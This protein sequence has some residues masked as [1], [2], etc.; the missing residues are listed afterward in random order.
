MRTG[1]LLAAGGR[2]LVAGATA[3]ACWWLVE[4]AVNWTVGGFVPPALL[5]RIAALDLALGA[6]FGLAVGGVLGVAGQLP[7]AVPTALA[8]AVGHGFIRVFAPPGV[9]AEAAFLVAAAAAV[10]AGLVLAGRRTGV[11]A[12]LHLT[13]LATVATVAGAFALD[14]WSG[15]PLGGVRLPLVFAVLPLVGLAADRVLALPLPRPGRRVAAELALAAAAAVVWGQPLAPGPLRDPV[16]TA[17]PPPAGTPD[18][19]LVSLDTTRADR[20]STYGYARETSPHLSAL[21]ADALRFDAARSPSSWTLPGHASMFTG[22][23]PSRHGARLAGAWLD[24][25]SVDGRRRVAHPLPARVVTLA[26]AL[27][28]RGYRTGGFVANFSYLYRD[29]G[30]AQGFGVYDDA[31]GLLLRVRPHAVR[32]A[33]QLAPGFCLKPFRTA[34]EMNAA[35]LAW[36]DGAAAG[37]PA[38]L[39]LNYMEPHQ[40]WLAPAPFDRWSRDL[41]DARRLARKNLYT[42]AVH[43]LTPA[44]EAF[45][46]ANY[47]GQV[48]AMDAA[49]GELIAALKAR[50][51]YEQALI[52]VTADHGELL[53][54]HGQMG[55]IGRMMYE[56]LL[57]V[58]LVVKLPGA[59]RPRG[60]VD[61]PVQLVDVLPTVLA[62][63]GAPLPPGVQGEALPAVTRASVAEEEINPFL[64]AHYGDVYNRSLRVVYDGA[65]KLITTS[66]GEQLLFDLQADPGETTDLSAREPERVSAMR[67]QLAAVLGDAVTVAT[68]SH[69]P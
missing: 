35:A 29:F 18:V 6:A 67:A 44:E 4:T 13:L 63:V 32:F 28:D 53:G 59:A 64:V 24:G 47:D 20:L 5:A 30:V 57:H 22:L 14:E 23:Y 65:W 54:E 55:H 48:A 68:V 25:Q 8:L 7:R 39:F 40:P 66:R 3:G 27:R 51:R 62:Q 2:G 15:Q 37:R 46:G 31:P 49:L 21:A 26:E 56:G 12:F 42:H 60:V 45:I 50:G 1:H 33:Q 10:A 36:L 61:T 16:V 19:V 41:P 52:V 34:P 38:F 11:L 43:D 9:G 17:V 69:G 58:P